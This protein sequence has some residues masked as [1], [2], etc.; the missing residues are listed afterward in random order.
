MRRAIDGEAPVLQTGAMNSEHAEAL[1]Q[2]AR[3]ARLDLAEEECRE[4]FD[5]LRSLLDAFGSI[6]T[7]DTRGIEPM[8]GPTQLHASMRSDSIRASLSQEEALGQAP[9]RIDGFYGVPKTVESTG[10]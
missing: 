6:G 2:A 5:S 8:S 10:S 3:L 1:S 4:L 7:I 9:E